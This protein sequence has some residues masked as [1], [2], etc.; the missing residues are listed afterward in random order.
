MTDTQE[1]TTNDL[2]DIDEIAAAVE[3]PTGAVEEK[4][5]VGMLT[6]SFAVAAAAGFILGAVVGT[7]IGRRATPPPPWWKLRR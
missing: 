7:A 3:S 4:T 1:R 6:A 2:P 5:A